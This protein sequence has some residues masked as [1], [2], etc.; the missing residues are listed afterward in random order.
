MQ[1]LE[2]HAVAQA[3]AEH[4]ES[5]R[6][7][8]SVCSKSCVAQQY[9]QSQITI[10]SES[11]TFG[12]GGSRARRPQ[13]KR[14]AAIPSSCIVLLNW[15]R[16]RASV[17]YMQLYYTSAHTYRPSVTKVNRSC[18]SFSFFFRRRIFDVAQPIDNLYSSKG[19]I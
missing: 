13:F 1:P 2:C 8:K 14:I 5:H 15:R 10:S 9:C 11:L 4:G 12:E 7:P 18:F 19:R 16:R 3:Q 17:G 6:V